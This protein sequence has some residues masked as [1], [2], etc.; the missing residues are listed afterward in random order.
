MIT[1]ICPQLLLIKYWLG[2]GFRRQGVG[3][4]LGYR[5]KRTARSGAK[6]DRERGRVS[7]E[8]PGQ[9]L[10]VRLVGLGLVLEVGQGLVLE[11]G[12]GLV[13]EVG[14]PGLVPEVGSGLVLEA[15]P[16]LVLE[17]GPMLVLESQGQGWC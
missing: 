8:G 6:V 9:G 11:V 2:L 14:P 10:E 3:L 17:M 4:E 13:P 7:K 1:H 12:P 5:E 16:G 15:D